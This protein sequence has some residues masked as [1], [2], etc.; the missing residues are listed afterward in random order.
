MYS[1]I[2]MPQVD[3]TKENLKYMFCFFPLI[4]L[5]IA[6]LSWLFA[7]VTAHFGFGELFIVAGLTLIPVFVTGGIHIDGLLDTADALSSWQSR[8]R[9]LEILKDSN[10]GA[11]AVITAGVYFLTWIGAYSEIVRNREFLLLM[12]LGFMESRCLSGL[13]VITF[14]KAKKEGTVAEFSLKAED[15]LVR[16]VLFLWLALLLGM[17]LYIH[18]LMGALVFVCGGLVFLF[19]HHMAMKYFGGITGDLAGFF[20]SLCEVSMAV[21]LAVFGNIIG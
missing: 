12:G 14:P 3:W 21:V 15:R 18:P 9:R 20:L 5:A 1:K 19:Y 17:M 6:G 10:S 4:G 8:E 7:Y 11:F 13:S 16:N 2:P